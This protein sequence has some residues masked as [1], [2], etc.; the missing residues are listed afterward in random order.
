VEVLFRTRKLQKICN[1]GRETIRHF[2]QRRGR[3]LQ[4]RLADIAAA[5]TLAELST[6]PQARCHPLSG[7]RTGQFAVDLEQPFRLIL[8]PA[9][10]P[11]PLKADAG[12]DLE[13]VTRVWIVEVTDYH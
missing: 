9:H 11:L 4:M 1:S 12:I 10:D 6:L 3:L 5:S 8:E 2:G 7:D 13:R